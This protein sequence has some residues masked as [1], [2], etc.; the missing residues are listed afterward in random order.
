MFTIYPKERGR[1]PYKGPLIPS[2]KRPEKKNSTIMPESLTTPGHQPFRFCTFCT[3]KHSHYGTLI[4]LQGF[5][6][7][8][9][10]LSL[11][12]ISTLPPSLESYTSPALPQLACPEIVLLLHT[13][14]CV[15]NFRQIPIRLLD[16]CGPVS[17]SLPSIYVALE[18]RGLAHLLLDILAEL[19][20]VLLVVCV[21]NQLEPARFARSIF[22]CT[23]LA[24]VPP[25]PVPT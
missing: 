3:W 8:Y 22:F 23:L 16:R 12:S 9:L 18:L 21:V 10:S 5:L 7:N 17:F 4:W 14:H 13:L 2:R 24:E 15:L 6:R 1:Y 19:A 11:L 25:S 20:S